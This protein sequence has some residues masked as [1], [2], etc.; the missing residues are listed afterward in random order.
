VNGMVKGPEEFDEQALRLAHVLSYHRGHS[1][2]Y[3]RSIQDL[4]QHMVSVRLARSTK[5][6]HLCGDL[7]N[8]RN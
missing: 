4:A 2:V 3:N 1:F 7:E 6:R 5:V 8:N